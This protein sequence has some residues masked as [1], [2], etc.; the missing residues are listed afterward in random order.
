MVA[1]TLLIDT[2]IFLY[3]ALFA[4]E[5][6]YDWGG[7]DFALT[8]DL[9]KAAALFRSRM[10]F[11]EEQCHADVLLCM[12]SDTNFRAKVWPE[13]KAT[14]SSKRKPIALPALKEIVR[15]EYPFV[16]KPGL[17]ADDV[18][19]ILATHPTAVPGKK[20]VVSIDKDMLQIPGKHLNPDK[21]DDGVLTL[22]ETEGDYMH[23]LQTLTGDVVD[24]YPGCPG[25]GPK[26]AAAILKPK[27]K[28]PPVWERIVVAYKAA[29]LTEDDALTQAQIARIC[30]VSDYD[31]AKQEVILWT[32][33]A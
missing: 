14:R 10:A 16:I 17:E 21:L 9:N 33:S 6:T 8:A 5:E 11:L 18:M 30:R 24:N 4:S 32:P 7:G 1:R 26:R 3:K 28:A 31:S 23:M 15:N 22:T 2:D 19:G 12:S 13:Y 27:G 29:N 20:L 25:I